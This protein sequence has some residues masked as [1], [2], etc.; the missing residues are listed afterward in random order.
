MNEKIE[1]ARQRA[2]EWADKEF[3]QGE[4]EE[5]IRDIARN[6]YYSALEDVILGIYK[7]IKR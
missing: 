6:A 1:K 3:P 4:C 5:N 7:V 2:N